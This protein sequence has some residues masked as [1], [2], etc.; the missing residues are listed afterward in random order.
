MH[1]W[2]FSFD[3][4][5]YCG[6]KLRKAPRRTPRRPAIAL[7][8]SVAGDE[9][10]LAHA[11]RTL[12][13][14]RNNPLTPKVRKHAKKHLL[15]VHQIVESETAGLARI[16]DDIVIGS[17]HAVRIAPGRNLL[18]AEFLQSVLLD[19]F[20]PDRPLVRHGP[21]QVDVSWRSQLHPE[22]FCEPGPQV[23]PPDE[24]AVGDVKSLVGAFRI[25][26][27]PLDGLC[28]KGS[29]RT[30]VKCG[31]GSRLA[32]K[33]ERQPQCLADVRIDGDRQG[34]VHRSSRGEPANRVRTPDRPGP[35]LAFLEFFKKV[36]LI[37]IEIRRHM[38]RIVFLGRS[39][40]GTEMT[41]VPP[42][43]LREMNMIERR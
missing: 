17:E 19:Y 31:K 25:G 24:I 10:A 26:C 11:M 1:S 27:H 15:G 35:A 21:C 7:I 9:V 33:A 43:A 3:N 6:S 12:G 14:S 18:E 8:A 29:V 39:L 34:Q 28:Q 40:V 13:R 37:V 30:L 32:R 41:S 20:S 38:P 5:L 4:G 22:E 36:L 2:M 23:L 42:G 16:G